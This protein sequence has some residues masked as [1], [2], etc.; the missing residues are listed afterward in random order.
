MSF[1]ACGLLT[2]PRKPERPLARGRRGDLSH[3]LI[4]CNGVTRYPTCVFRSFLTQPPPMG[5]HSSCG[6]KR[7][8][9]GKSVSGRTGLDRG[10]QRHWAQVSND[11]ALDTSVQRLIRPPATGPR[12]RNAHKAHNAHT[13]AH[14]C[15]HAHMCR[16]L[17]GWTA[18]TSPSPRPRPALWRRCWTMPGLV[19][20]G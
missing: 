14:K 11:P 13:D 10:V 1:R 4:S 18:R 15:T 3:A 7:P 16:W 17:A 12:C 6:G 2:L 9:R 19:G 5:P 20:S 8:P